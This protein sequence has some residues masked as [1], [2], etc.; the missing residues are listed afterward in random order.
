M[1]IN[2]LIPTETQ[3][4]DEVRENVLISGRFYMLLHVRKPLGLISFFFFNFF[5]NLKVVMV[6]KEVIL[7]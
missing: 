7:H 3:C 2:Y 6:R 1:V 5:L 4:A